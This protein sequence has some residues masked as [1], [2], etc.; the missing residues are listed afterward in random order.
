MGLENAALQLAQA[1]ETAGAIATNLSR[2]ADL[3]ELL[4][5]E[6]ASIYAGVDVPDVLGR[7]VQDLARRIGEAGLVA[8]AV[9]LYLRR[10]AGLAD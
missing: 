10:A 1:G 3:A 2:V 7:D 5:E 4:R 6:V 9:R 8:V